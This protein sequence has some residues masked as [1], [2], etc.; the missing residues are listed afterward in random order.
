MKNNKNNKK[1]RKALASLGLFFGLAAVASVTFAAYV[2]G[3]GTLSAT[4]TTGPQIEILE[5]TY[6]VGIEYDSETFPLSF[7]PSV[8]DKSQLVY[9]SSGES[10]EQLT[11]YI[12]LSLTDENSVLESVTVSVTASKTL[13]EG[14]NDAES[15][16]YIVLP[17]SQTIQAA[18]FV[19]GSYALSLTFTWGTKFS[20]LNPAVYCNNTFTTAD[21]AV[22]YLEDFES[23]LEN[24]TL[25]FTATGKFAE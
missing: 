22:S 15:E 10:E 19:S 13:E 25:T 14:T 1:S 3:S 24:T 11:A 2:V 23:S 5:A 4:D 20:G 17:A 6:E 9:A 16:G 21:D 7:G 12:T 18:S 8:T